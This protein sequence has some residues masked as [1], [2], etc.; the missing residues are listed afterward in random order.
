[1][2]LLIGDVAPD[3]EADTTQ[4]HIRFYDYIDAAIRPTAARTALR[5]AGSAWEPA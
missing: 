5:S 3:F 2:A 4:G 1:M